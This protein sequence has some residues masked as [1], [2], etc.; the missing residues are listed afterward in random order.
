MFI[1]R[2]IREL[3]SNEDGSFLSTAIFLALVIVIMAIAV[4]DGASVFYAYQSAG[5]VTKEASRIASD[6]YKANRNEF[7]A[8]EAAIDYCEDKGL[9]FIEIKRLPELSSNAFEVTCEKDADTYVFKSLPW[10]RD[11]TH[12]RVTT[13]EY[14]SI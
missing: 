3:I 6:E 9:E 1:T 13:T 8:Q 11:L 14:R 5:E 7:R 4:I 2:R 12:Q 10:F